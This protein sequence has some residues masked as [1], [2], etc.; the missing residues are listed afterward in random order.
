MHLIVTALILCLAVG[1]AFAADPSKQWNVLIVTA[2]DMNADSG[3]WNGNKLG[4]TPNLDTFAKTAHR[5]VKSH[6]T[7]PI[8]QPSRSALMTGRVPHRNGALGFNPIRRDVPT[9]VELLRDHGYYTAVISKAVHMAPAEKF[10]WHATGEQDLGKQPTKFAEKFREML[11]TAAK[12]KKPF[13][14]NANIC[15]PHRP[16]IGAGAKADVLDGAKV[17]KPD[18]VTVP[19]FLEDIPRVREEVAQYYSSVSRFDVAFGLVMKELTAAGRDADTVVA[20][21]SDHGMPFPFSKATVYYNGTWSPVLIR[22]PG[23]KEPQT[24]TEFVSSVDVMPS[25]LELLSV[26]PPVGMDGRSWVPLLKGETQPDRDFVVTHVNTVSSGKSFAQRCVR[27]KDRSLMF[28]AWVGGPDK[29]RVEAMSGLSF[30]AMNASKDAKIQARVKQLVDGEPLMLFDTA[31]DPTERKNLINDPKY[32]NDVAKLSK[33]LL[34]HMKRT[35]DPQTKAFEV[36]ATSPELRPEH[37]VPEAPANVG[38]VLDA[39]CVSCHGPAKRKGK[40][41]VHDLDGRLSIGHDVERWEKVLK[42]LRNGEM[43]PEEA[44][45]PSDAERKAVVNWIEAGL[46]DHARNAGATSTVPTARRLTN[47]EYQNTMRDLLGFELD[48]VENLPED[49]VK[50]YKFNNTAELMLIGPEQMDRYTENA[51]RAMASAI[52]DPEKPKVHRTVQTWNAKNPPEPGLQ[53]NE[54]GIYGNRR[55]S[56]GQGVGLKSWPV[57]GEFRIRVKASAILPPGYHEMPLRLV[58]GSDLNENSS[59]LRIRPVGTEQLRNP[60]DKPMVLEFRGRI[61]NYPTRPGRDTKEG[62]KS[63]PTMTITPQNLFDDGRLNDN[64]KGFDSSWALKVPR[65]VI[66]S[67]E[68][69]APIIDVWPPEHHTRILFESPLR[70]TD[71]NAYVREVLQR[72][73]SRAFRRPVTTDEL[74]RFVKIYKIYAAEFDTLEKAMRETLAMVLISPQF[75][76]HTTAENGSATRQY[77]LA[78]KLSYFLWGSMPDAK[79]IEL[80]SQ[81]RLDDPAVVQAEVLRL[82]ADGRSQGFV[83]NFTTQWL[84]LEKMKAVKINTELFPRFLYLVHLGERK[85]TEVPYRPTIRDFMHKET[86]GFIAELIR[87]NANVKNIVDSDFAFL[88]QPLAEHYGVEGV[89]GNELRPVA[90]KPEHHLGGLLTQGSVLVGNST[91]SAPHPIY[92][93]VWLREA[94]LGDEVKPPP[95]EVP[96]LSDT[97]GDSSAKAVLINS[98]CCRRVRACRCR[99]QTDPTS[100][101]FTP[102]TSAMGTSVATA[103]RR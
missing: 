97:A 32:A 49:P 84:S 79:L 66:D 50:P 19:A 37:A 69:E 102:T 83:D 64:L 20:F 25:L 42:M 92:R 35:E 85:G 100:C 65:A 40:I 56:V 39:F 93:A 77:E 67:I 11:A 9:L 68:F 76:F 75:L 54:L 101:S 2:D 7:A 3:G 95:A 46:A 22:I 45:Q 15:D 17:Y 88:N 38:K 47:F 18:E 73:T 53:P 70:K 27:T 8:C 61:E 81:R 14:I 103:R 34:A 90:I 72:F 80:A 23:M 91:G 52:V 98:S 10:P 41:T 82:L 29:F 12:E 94:I 58:M 26:K 99:L 60:P 1:D 55:G 96:A 89:E 87:R 63:P 57:T 31:V 51:R 24:R 43:P 71:P 36:A 5:F 86:V 59:T 16:F 33:M 21:L 48:L 6:V 28:H 13:F 62:A 44:K 30:A 74:D 78:S 4:A